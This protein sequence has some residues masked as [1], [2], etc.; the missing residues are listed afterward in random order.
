MWP[1]RLLVVFNSARLVRQ[2][3]ELEPHRGGAGPRPNRPAP[4]RLH[5]RRLPLNA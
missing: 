3:E 5:W 4:R 2:G 1:A